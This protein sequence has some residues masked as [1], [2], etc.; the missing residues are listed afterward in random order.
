MEVNFKADFERTSSFKDLNRKV[1]REARELKVLRQ[2]K[3]FKLSSRIHSFMLRTYVLLRSKQQQMQL[4]PALTPPCS[5]PF[6]FLPSAA[7][8]SHHVFD[9]YMHACICI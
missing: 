5:L 2:V 6:F 3:I 4:M 7:K 1:E 9:L 8:T